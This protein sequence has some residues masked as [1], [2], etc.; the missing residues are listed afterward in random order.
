MEAPANSQQST[1]AVIS[2]FCGPGGFD[3][4]FK[5][6]GF[7]TRLAYDLDA[8]SINTHRHNH[9]HA[10]AKLADLS[11]LKAEDIVQEWKSRC[12]DIAPVGI[13][14]G[15]PCQS[16][17]V[18][19]VHKKAR[20]PR[21]NLPLHYAR[22][23]KELND[24]FE[25]DFFVFENVPGLLSEKHVV[26]YERFKKLFR[27]CG[28]NVFEAVMDAQD[29]G[30]AQVRKR[31]FIVG[32]NEKKHRSVIFRFPS[33]TAL[34]ARTV[35]EAIG[36]LPNPTPFNRDLKPDDIAFHP[37]HW[38]LQPRSK[39]F[40]ESPD[41][42]RGRKAG[43]SFRCLSWDKPSYTVAYGHREVH[44]HPDGARRLSV[45]EALCLQGFPSH[46]VLKGTLSDQLRLVSEA[47]P[48]PMAAAIA[49]AVKSQLGWNSIAVAD[50]AER[51]DGPSGEAKEPIKKKRCL[52]Q[53]FIT[54]WKSSQ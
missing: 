39:R 17:S 50:A 45:F 53:S 54:D 31:V 40:K 9:P 25:L 41:S 36:D 13:L 7:V 2:L 33:P 4:G 35:R 28:F 51:T 43:R 30:V 21:D 1:L 20:D 12:P 38:Y 22:I 49:S 14:G 5:E 15:P 6:S 11:T 27:D 10:D 29:F 52:R 19:N 23:L 3:Q 46:Y 37:N 47:V 18:S 24:E 44:V 32:L 42:L 8:A 16:F 48:P 26:K 34:T